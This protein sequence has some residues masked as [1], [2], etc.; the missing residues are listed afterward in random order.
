M[1]HVRQLLLESN[2]NC[3]Y[4][5]FQK[6]MN[7][8]FCDNLFVRISCNPLE[9]LRAVFRA[10]THRHLIFLLEYYGKINVYCV[11][12]FKEWGCTEDYRYN[13]PLAPWSM[14]FGKIWQ[15]EKS[16]ST[17][18]RGSPQPTENVFRLDIAGQKISMKAF[19]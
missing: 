12:F 5:P 18:L 15:A 4:F 10:V 2:Y 1:T 3:N 13:S 11:L 6:R 14:L 8:L 17:W 19:L 7:V 16:Q 9:K